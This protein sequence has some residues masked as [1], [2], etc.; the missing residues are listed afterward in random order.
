MNNCIKRVGE[1]NGKTVLFLGDSI[2]DGGTYVSVIHTYFR[3]YLTDCNVDIR[4]LG[5]CSETVSGLSEPDHPFPRPCA[6]GRVDRIMEEIHP[7]LVVTCYGINDGIYYPFSEEYLNEYKRGYNELVDRIHKYGAKAAVMTPPPFDTVSFQGELAEAGDEKYSFMKPYKEYCEVMKR[8]ADWIRAEMPGKADCVIDLYT[9]LFNE[10]ENRRIGDPN[11]SSG[12]GIHPNRHGHFIMADSIMRELFYIYAP[13]F[14]PLMKVDNF[15]LTEMIHQRDDLHHCSDKETIGHDNEF[16]SEYLE[17]SALDIAL[18][19]HDKEIDRYI[20]EHTELINQTSTWCDFTEHQFHFGGYEAGVV[21][22]EVIAVGRPYVWRTEFFGAFPSADLALLDAGWHIVYLSIPNRYGCPA[23]VHEMVE[24]QAF[25]QE[26]FNLNPKVV[27]FGFS[28][29]GLYA[30]HY[31]AA[32]P[33]RIS[34]LYLDAPVVDI[35][36]WPGRCK[37]ANSLLEWHDCLCN[38]GLT[39]ETSENY[40][41]ILVEACKQLAKHKLPLIIVAGDSDSV[42]PFKENGKLLCGV[43]DVERVPYKL[44]LKPG[45]GHHPHSLED[46]EPITE[47]LIENFK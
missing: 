6:L 22:P 43:Y 21:E 46:P 24:F 25:V 29:G 23:A 10:N 19:E 20:S 41:E 44:I 9:A 33:D 15:K 7:D 30:I 40:V 27:L 11:Y 1:L 47:F 16:K 37:D 42:V 3:L 17:K 36:S 8:Y 31:A 35:N 32:F 45:V 14:E 5:V 2:T 38:F 26:K 13:K 4:N 39:E 12:D 34:A 28:R 18:A